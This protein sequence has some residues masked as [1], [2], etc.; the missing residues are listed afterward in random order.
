MNRFRIDVSFSTHDALQQGIDVLGVRRVSVLAHNA[1]DA[2][3]AAAQMVACHG[4]M[5]TGTRIIR[6]P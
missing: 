3:L 2:C 4:L 5:P 6:N 1:A